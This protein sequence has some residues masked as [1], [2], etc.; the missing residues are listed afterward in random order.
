LGRSLRIAGYSTAPAY[1]GDIH[2]YNDPQ[3]P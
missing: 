1:S 2:A 3:G